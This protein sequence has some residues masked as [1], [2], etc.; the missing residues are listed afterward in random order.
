[1]IVFSLV[2]SRIIRL[3]IQMFRFD[4]KTITMGQE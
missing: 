1:M 4:V 2:F 3:S